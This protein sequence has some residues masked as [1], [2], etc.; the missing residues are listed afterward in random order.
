M[1]PAPVVLVST[2]ELGHQPLALASAA[3]ALRGR[4][5]TVDCVDLA[6]EECAP[7]QFRAAVL[8]AIAMP[9]HTAARLAIPLAERLRHLN[10]RA[11]IAC[12][13]VY[14][15]LL[16]DTLT[17][18]RGERAGGPIADSVIGGEHEPGLCALADRLCGVP[19]ARPA[20]ELPADAAPPATL[21]TSFARQ[22]FLRPDRVTLPPL[23]RYARLDPG[24]GDATPG[25]GSAGDGAG[26][27]ALP[28]AGHVEASRGCAYRCRHCPITAVYGGRLRLVQPE[29][30]L[31]DIAQQVE[32]GARHISFGDPDFLNAVGHSLG[33]VET[34]HARHPDVTFDATI[35]VEHLLEH[36]A[37]LPRLRD[38]GCLFITSAFESCDDQVLEHFDKG[39]TAHDLERVMALAVA[40]RMVIRPTWLPFTPWGTVDGFIELLDFIERHDLVQHVA[41]V[42]YGIRLLLPPGSWLLPAVRESGLLGPFDEPSLSYAWSALD[43]RSTALQQEVA[44]LVA[45]GTP[46]S[47]DGRTDHSPIFTEVKRAAVRAAGRDPSTVEAPHTA[48]HAV[49]GLTEAWFC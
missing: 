11:H 35:K 1:T 28:L 47:P 34:M 15:P 45:Q 14:A 43:P 32:A 7:E 20:E 9:M 23:E 40:E 42:Q 17:A 24:D 29:S 26:D 10:P 30:V 27:T 41:P 39:H 44:A 48:A 6:V 31:A 4:G 19:G 25:A 21:H 3:A 33:I 16:H 38:L 46:H 8:I 49:P 22:R 37:L 13:G 5:H 36:N 12:Y 18:E 2:Y